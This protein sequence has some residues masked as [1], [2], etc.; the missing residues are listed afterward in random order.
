MKRYCKQCGTELKED[1]MF[2]SKCGK[3]LGLLTDE[4]DTGIKEDILDVKEKTINNKCKSN[5]KNKK[6]V[7]MMFVCVF[8]LISLVLGVKFG[9]F[10]NSNNGHGE[11]RKTVDK[12]NEVEEKSN[13]ENELQR[14]SKKYQYNFIT[15]DAP[16]YARWF[17]ESG[18]LFCISDYKLYYLNQETGDMGIID[19][20]EIDTYY[21]SSRNNNWIVFND[22]KYV[23]KLNVKD[24][25]VDVLLKINDGE[26]MRRIVGESGVVVDNC[27]YYYHEKNDSS[28]STNAVI[29]KKNLEDD[30]ESQ[31]IVENVATASPIV[32]SNSGDANLYYSE[33]LGDETTIKRFDCK[34]GKSEMIGK[35]YTGSLVVTGENCYLF[36]EDV[37]LLKGQQEICLKSNFLFFKEGIVQSGDYL[38]CDSDTMDS[39]VIFE[40]ENVYEI[41]K[42][43]FEGALVLEDV[44]F[45]Q[46]KRIWFIVRDEALGDMQY[47]FSVDF[48]GNISDTKDWINLKDGDFVTYFNQNLWVLG[49]PEEDW[50][51][52]KAVDDSIVSELEKQGYDIASFGQFENGK[53]DLIINVGEYGLYQIPLDDVTN[54]E[55]GKDIKSNKKNEDDK[56]YQQKKAVEEK[57]KSNE[58]VPIDEYIFPDSNARYL[59]QEEVMA[60]D[61]SLLVFARNEIFARHGRMFEDQ[62]LQDYFNNLSWYKG[63]I[64]GSEFDTTVINDMNSYEKANIDMIKEV[65]ILQE[66]FAE[67]RNW[68]DSLD[69]TQ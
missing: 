6:V 30:S 53:T 45:A 14:V 37:I 5:V 60:I 21:P 68:N 32:I 48:S 8:L 2:C 56:L 54:T 67:Q 33:G 38:I 17:E 7:V 13:N 16:G 61:P 43:W 34:T 50:K 1:A 28:A 29:C 40:G 55:S 46:N 52:D 42:T 63:T 58:N 27:F 47:I 23:Y 31:V 49:Q 3:K 69:N 41:E 18:E 25:T 65:E 19:N 51:I 4:D 12:S 57:G 66:D 35:G 24:K 22:N 36:E 44:I 62:T 11:T 15:A 39:L 59:S 64:S 26:T 9:V 20:V 10:S